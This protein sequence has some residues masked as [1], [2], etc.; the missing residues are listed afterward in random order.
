[1]IRAMKDSLQ[2]ESDVFR[3][4]RRLKELLVS[5]SLKL[6]LAGKLAEVDAGTIQTLPLLLRFLLSLL[7]EVRESLNATLVRGL[8]VR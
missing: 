6:Q 7:L 4:V 8:D 1:M 3:H 2:R 5:T